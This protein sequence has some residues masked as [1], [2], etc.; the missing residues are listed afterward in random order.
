MRAP[1]LSPA[2]GSSPGG[3]CGAAPQ[4]PTPTLLCGGRGASRRPATPRAPRSRV[5]T[6]AK[7]LSVSSIMP[8]MTPEEHLTLSPWEK[9]TRFRRFPVKFVVQMGLV[10]T[11]SMQTLYYAD[12]VIPYFLDT[13]RT[14]HETFFGFQVG[15]KRI[16]AIWSPPG[17]SGRWSAEISHTDDFSHSIRY[18]GQKY[19]QFPQQSIDKYDIPNGRPTVSAQIEWRSDKEYMARPESLTDERRHADMDRHFP[20]HADCHDLTWDDQV[21][22]APGASCTIFSIDPLNTTEDGLGPFGAFADWDHFFPRLVRLQLQ[23][24]LTD[25]DASFLTKL[26]KSH[27]TV[28]WTV[29]AVYTVRSSGMV[30]VDYDTSARL[31]NNQGGV[32][33]FKQDGVDLIYPEGFGAEEEYS[34]WRWLSIGTITLASLSFVLCARALIS[35]WLNS[36]ALAKYP[37][38]LPYLRAQEKK[39][40]SRAWLLLTMLQNCVNVISAV[41]LFSPEELSQDFTETDWM[42]STSI[43]L[44]LLNATRYL[45]WVSRSP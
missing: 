8:P 41:Q 4:P 23:V 32:D 37:Q 15:E 18:L 29:T 17:N 20:P 9:C 13:D 34:T 5:Q 38:S 2:A 1:L 28:D 21:S 16:D 24:A 25:H 35:N 22:A 36:R 11:C 39:R 31:N 44:T 26:G 30:Q 27:C 12:E 6:T 40:T 33:V 42:L 7:S 43:F 45:E 10:I 19:A 3:R 14:M